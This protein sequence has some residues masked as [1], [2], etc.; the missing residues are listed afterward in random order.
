ML[1]KLKLR[2]PFYFFFEKELQSLYLLAPIAL[3]AGVLVFFQLKTDPSIVRAAMGFGVCVLLSL[4]AYKKQKLFFTSLYVT[5]FAAGFFF[6]TLRTDTADTIVIKTLDKPVW[7]RADLEKIERKE[8]DVTMVLRNND[9]WRPETKSFPKNET[10]QKIRVTVKTKMADGILVG[11]RLAFKAMLMPPSEKPIYPGGYDF[12]RIAYYQKIG[13][14]GYAISEV[15]I[16]EKKKANII[17]RFQDYFYRKVNENVKDKDDAGIIVSQIT[18]DRVEISKETKKNMQNSG[19]GHL[20]AISGLNMSVAMVWIFFIA[21][22]ALSFSQRLALQYDIKKISCIIALFFGLAYL[23]V[24][25]MPVSAVRAFLMVLLFFIAV[26]FDRFSISLHPVAFAALVILVLRPENVISPGFQLSFAAVI[27]LIGMY[28]AYERYFKKDLNV[29]RGF[30]KKW[31]LAF[32]GITTSTLFTSITTAPFGI[33]HFGT[34]QNYGVFA[35]MIGVP[36]VSIIVLPFSFL[37]IL[38]MPLGIEKPFLMVAEWGANV[39]KNLSAFISAKQDSVTYAADIPGNFIYY[40]VA[41]FLIFFI[42]KTRIRFLGIPLILFGYYLIM[43]KPDMPD[44][45]VNETGSLIA[46]KQDDGGYKYLGINRD[47]FALYQFNSKLGVKQPQFIQGDKSCNRKKCVYKAVAVGSFWSKDECGKYAY[48]INLG[49]FDLK[50]D[51]AKVIDRTAL[52][53]S[54]SQLFYLKENKVITAADSQNKRI[55]NS[56]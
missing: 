5:F 47:S 23:L 42:F 41:G 52:K 7:I 30:V 44:L 43:Q 50:C 15:K 24:T 53:A 38:A 46:M 26:F 6:A 40:V 16:F 14:I 12:G 49:K 22:Y 2:N 11:D 45:V 48:M 1:S 51:K 35:N 56:R 20:I 31:L 37:S 13:A 18:A 55:W 32:A 34:F 25:G 9:L 21:R 19:L 54:G 4:I 28:E 27:G 8:K 39:I 29:D 36:V 17:D 10:P 33:M 3:G